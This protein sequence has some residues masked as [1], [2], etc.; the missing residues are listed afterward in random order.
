MN[1]KEFAQLEKVWRTAHNTI[2]PSSRLDE[3]W[4][5]GLM[6]KIYAEA[7]NKAAQKAPSIFQS[8]A[9][10][11]PAACGM[12]ATAVGFAF[13]LSMQSAAAERVYLAVSYFESYVMNF[14][15]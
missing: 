2:P 3:T 12:A 13:W 5:H 10:L 8:L 15:I 14:P 1:E 6:T 11:W 9:S 4:R 7:M